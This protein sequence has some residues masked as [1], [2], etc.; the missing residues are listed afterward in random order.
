VRYEGC[1]HLY[2]LPLVPGGG[3]SDGG[4]SGLQTS[5]RELLASPR[6][7]LAFTRPNSKRQGRKLTSTAAHASRAAA[8][9]AAAACASSGVSAASTT[10]QQPPPSTQ[11]AIIVTASTRCAR[12]KAPARIALARAA[13]SLHPPDTSSEMRSAV[14][15]LGE[16]GREHSEGRKGGEGVGCG[17]ERRRRVR[18]AGTQKACERARRMDAEGGVCGRGE[19]SP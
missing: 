10:G 19:S 8:R 1:P 15:H 9:D 18:S 4:D 6:E 7:L 12:E 14:A 16:S 11:P 13:S 17:W 5:P 2:A 3:S